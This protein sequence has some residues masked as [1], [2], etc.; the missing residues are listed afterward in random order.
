MSE[1]QCWLHGEEPIPRG[2]YRV[3]GEC[4]HAFATAG[5]LLDAER[6]ICAEMGF[7]GAES[8]EDVVVCPLCTHDF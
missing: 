6:R 2:C 7:T 5:E 8:A 3:C 1:D 4:G